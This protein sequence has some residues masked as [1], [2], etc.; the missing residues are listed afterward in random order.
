MTNQDRDVWFA[1]P[2]A[3][4]ENCRRV[5]PKWREAGYKVAVLQNRVRAEIPADVVVWSDYYPG[6]ADS[7]NMLC[8][9]V[10]PA[11]AQVVVSGGDDMLPDPNHSA[12]ELGDEF[13]RH[14][15]DLFGV[16]QPMGD[17]ALGSGRFC[18]SPWLGRG[19]ISKA[20]AGLGPMP[21]GY[22]HNWADNELYWVA[23]GLG[24]LWERPD[25][26]QM[27]EHFSRKHEAAPD[28]WNQVVAANDKVDVERFI[29]RLWL[30]FPGHQPVRDAHVLDLN[31]IRSE[32]QR[33]AEAYWCTRYAKDLLASEPE[34]RM[35]RALEECAARSYRR[36]AIFGAGTHTRLAGAALAVPPVEVVCVIDDDARAPRQLWGLPVVRV[37][38]AVQLSFD[39]VI[40]SS[41]TQEPE[42]RTRARCFE[43]R[44]AVVMSLYE[45][46]A[47]PEISPQ[48]VQ[49]H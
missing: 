43:E 1:I 14:F 40:L 25:L 3:N 49:T 5:L 27:H 37:E 16:M 33:T 2:S 7:I 44:G 10:V 23:K 35:A 19:W 26:T 29:A 9:Q 20:Y 30:G 32:Y 17:R 13:V 21:S 24:V 11:S 46:G 6:W 15:P 12:R 4:P 18:G 22:R 41:K 48:T 31:L 36:V 39:A 47:K 34:A 42:L 8:K 38:Q 45:E 28:Y